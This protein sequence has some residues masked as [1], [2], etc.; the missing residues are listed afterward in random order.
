MSGGLDRVTSYELL[1]IYE[2]QCDERVKGRTLTSRRRPRRVSFPVS[3]SPFV[4]K[5][6][7][8]LVHLALDPGGVPARDELDCVRRDGPCREARFV[9][10]VREPPVPFGRHRGGVVVWVLVIL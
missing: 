7:F 8:G 10:D 6:P 2:L 3:H 4:V 9:V 5:A 1:Y